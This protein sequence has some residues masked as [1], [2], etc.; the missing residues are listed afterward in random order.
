LNT[1]RTHARLRCAAG[2]PS[3]GPVR[4]RLK[5]TVGGVFVVADVF[6]PCHPRNLRM[7]S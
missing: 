6:N 7:I 2:R 5:S 4:W 1:F 3:H